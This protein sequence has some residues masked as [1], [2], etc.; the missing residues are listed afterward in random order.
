MLK[1]GAA[2]VDVTPPLGTHLA[3]SAGFLRE[4]KVVLERLFA[5]ALVLEQDGRTLCIVAPD[6]AMI[7][8]PW[9]RRIR[10]AIH[11]QCGIA[12]DDVMISF[13][14][15][16]SAPPVG[17]INPWPGFTPDFVPD[18]RRMG[19]ELTRTVETLLP[20]LTYTSPSILEGSSRSIP[21]PIRDVSPKDRA[22][23]EKMLHD[24]PLPL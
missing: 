15:I 1:A 4:G 24:H 9:S 6:L 3:G 10:Q 22:W 11:E 7:A 14:Q 17:N 12:Y 8:A 20:T 21:L 23:A 18:H 16:H 2:R 13:P 19:S 5:R